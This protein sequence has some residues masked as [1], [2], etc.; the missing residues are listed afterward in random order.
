MG[1][2]HTIDWNA[3][4]EAALVAGLAVHSS[5]RGDWALLS[6]SH[7]TKTHLP[8]AV[9]AMWICEGVWML[10]LREIA[11]I[12]EEEE[13]KPSG[14]CLRPQ[15]LKG[16]AERVGPQTRADISSA[17]EQLYGLA[18]KHLRRR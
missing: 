17:L 10:R 2:D 15:N 18:R 3:L 4:R 8:A 12:L 11:T 5:A 13:A 9:I 1:C 16:K 14:E 6:V 7:R